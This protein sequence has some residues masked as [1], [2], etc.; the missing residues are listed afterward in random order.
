PVILGG[1]ALTRRY[2]E[3]DCRRVYKGTLFY[4]QDAF[5]DLKIMEAL[6]S[7]D[8][9]M[10]NKMMGA[11]PGQH[12]PDAE[13]DDD[14]TENG[15]VR[16]SEKRTEPQTLDFSPDDQ[17]AERPPAKVSTNGSKPHESSDVKRNQDTF[18]PPFWGSRV[19][20]DVP[21]SQVFKYINENALIRGQWRVRQGDSSDAEYEQLLES[22]VRPVL[23]EL[24]KECIEKKL[25]VPK[26]V[27]GY[28]PV[29]AEGNDLI[30]YKVN[31][32]FLS[33]VQDLKVMPGARLDL[34][35][36]SINNLE[37][38]TRFS[39]PRQD[40]ARHLC[41][42][43]FF[44]SRSEGL[45]DVLPAQIVT[46]GAGASLH[47]EQLFKGD[48]YTDYLYFHGLSVESAEGLAEFMHKRVREELGL[49]QF[50]SEDR[51]KF[52]QQGYR[53]TRYSFGYPAC[54]NLEDQVQLFQLLEPERIGV[55]LSEEFML[56]PEQS[57]SAVVVVHPEA[58]YFN[59]KRQESAR[60]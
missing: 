28:F 20:E 18:A 52:F 23:R 57:T 15:A 33:A 46:M 54:P 35:A 24:E 5:D 26:A 25:L 22:K 13:D 34:K 40:H 45:I 42:S 4:G 47:S 37:E 2:V 10:L 9:E 49:A 12:N 30:V 31:D 58:K 32:S 29:Q 16:V 38:W 36:V 53:G 51:N 56:V 7:K 27:Y 1:A 17:S 44:H 55:S 59:V 60:V 43:D 6:A 50:D 3:D 14:E 21:L 41:I 8:Q 11:Q 19:V 48:K 39:F